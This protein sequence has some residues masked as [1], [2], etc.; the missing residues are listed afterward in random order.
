MCL[1]FLVVAA[2]VCT[3]FLLTIPQTP[4]PAGAQQT[5]AQ[6]DFDDLR[7]QASAALEAFISPSD[8]NPAGTPLRRSAGH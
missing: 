6:I 7:A 5:A 4:A 2:V 3:G 1:R 8:L